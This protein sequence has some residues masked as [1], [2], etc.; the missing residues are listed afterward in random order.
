MISERLGSFL[1][2][3]SFCLCERILSRMR[4]VSSMYR[5]WPSCTHMAHEPAKFSKSFGDMK[6]FLSTSFILYNRSS[7]SERTY[8]DSKICEDPEREI[9]K[10]LNH[11]ESWGIKIRARTKVP[12]QQVKEGVNSSRNLL[13]TLK[14]H[15]L[16]STLKST[17]KIVKNPY[18]VIWIL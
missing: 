11:F 15:V 6:I 1:L 18:K 12:S 14:R 16:T 4:P 3:S 2:T 5:R 17:K 13:W 7:L 10:Q 9:L 8:L